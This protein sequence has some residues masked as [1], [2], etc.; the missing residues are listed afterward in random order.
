[1]NISILNKGEATVTV[2]SSCLQ[3]SCWQGKYYCG[4]YR[5]AGTKQMTVRELR[6]LNYE[7]ESYWAEKA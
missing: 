3:A 1:M 7:H 4:N 5:N 2:C 6:K